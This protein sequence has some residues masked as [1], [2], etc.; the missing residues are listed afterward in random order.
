MKQNFLILLILYLTN[1]YSIFSQIVNSGT[2]KV[3]SSTLVYFGN[4]YTNNGT[5]AN[6]GDLYLNSNFINNDSTS[7]YQELL[8][9]IVL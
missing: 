9:L 8:F 7:E 3:E 1:S 4:E 6:D 2:L 5:H